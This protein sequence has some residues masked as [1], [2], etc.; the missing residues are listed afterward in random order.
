MLLHDLH[1]DHD[2]KNPFLHYTGGKAVDEAEEHPCSSASPTAVIQSSGHK[3]KHDGN[4]T[5][6]QPSRHQWTESEYT[7][8]E[9]S[10]SLATRAMMQPARSTTA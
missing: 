9:N 3:E 5:P 10:F 7:R 4:N 6:N 8:R 1:V 2:G